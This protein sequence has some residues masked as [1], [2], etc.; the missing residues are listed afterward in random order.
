MRKKA[1]Y[2]LL[3]FAAALLLAAWLVCVWNPLD[4]VCGDVYVMGVGW[5]HDLDPTLHRY[6]VDLL[7]LSH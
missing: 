6:F 3:C 7:L 2:C 5:I 4:L 1:A